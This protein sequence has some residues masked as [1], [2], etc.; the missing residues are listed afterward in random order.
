[1]GITRCMCSTQEPIMIFKR[2]LTN[3]VLCDVVHGLHH[4]VLLSKC[5]MI[6]WYTHRCSFIYARKIRM[7][8]PSA[9]FMELT[10]D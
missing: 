10:N 7:A 4:G 2:T 1:M 9:I 3:N 5:H 8:F 6:L